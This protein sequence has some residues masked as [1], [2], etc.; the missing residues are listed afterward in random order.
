MYGGKNEI[1]YQVFLECIK[2]TCDI[3]WQNIF[4]ELSYG[5]CPYGIYISNDYICCNYKDKKFSYNINNN[6]DNSERLYT[7]VYDILKHTFGLLSKKDKLLNNNL[8]LKKQEDM[9]LML[10]NS[11][12]NIKKKNIKTLLL[13]KFIIKKSKQ[14][15]LTSKQ[16]KLLYNDIVLGL[17][18]KTINKTHIIYNDL[19]IRE[20]KYLT[21]KQHTYKFNTDIYNFKNELIFV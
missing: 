16:S 17:L 6:I 13:E 12:S 1:I 20:I 8:F 10:Q 18:F 2:Y 15:N 5:R 4:E 3:F 21:F 7:E 11:W 19:E 14:Y 9:V